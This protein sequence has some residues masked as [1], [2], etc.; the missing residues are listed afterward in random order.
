MT[1]LA[2]VTQALQDVAGVGRYFAVELAA[3]GPQWLPLRQLVE[4][5]PTRLDRV[6]VVCTELGRRCGRPAAELDARAAA[7]IWFQG[8]A[9]RLVVPALG[10]AA[11]AE[12][13]PTFTVADA[14]W[15]RVDGGPIPVALT[16]VSAQATRT[17][18]SAA[19]ALDELAT[20][21]V[22]PLVDA[23][24]ADVSRRVLWGNV[25][26]SLA[27]AA[28]TLR[29][30]DAALRLDPAA[31]VTALL[32]RPGPMHAAGHFAEPER[33]YVRASC[34]LFYRI[35]DGGKCGDCVLL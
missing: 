28:G 35:P 10:T 6:T 30:S 25:A 14:W 17:P 13:V 27:S 15:Q 18:E 22:A 2:D 32:D 24:G 11:T 26:S 8:L 33:W 19:A 31:I 16:G 7:S 4:D 1:E 20:A 34:C 29:R 21:V 23:F 9:A 12:L 3:D 5:A